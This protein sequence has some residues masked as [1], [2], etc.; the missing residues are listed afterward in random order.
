[1]DMVLSGWWL[2]VGGLLHLCP[3]VDAVAE[4]LDVQNFFLR[5]LFDFAVSTEGCER[6]R[7]FLGRSIGEEITVAFRELDRV[8]WALAFLDGHGLGWL[9]GWLVA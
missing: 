6:K 5:D 7:N 9:V 4:E 1:M 8:G 2:R 3:D